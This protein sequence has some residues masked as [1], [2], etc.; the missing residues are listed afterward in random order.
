[1]P[2]PI[3]NIGRNTIVGQERQ[4]ISAKEAGPGRGKQSDRND[5]FGGKG[6]AGE[7]IQAQIPECEKGQARDQAAA[8]VGV[9]PRYVSDAA[10]LKK[11][12]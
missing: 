1:M 9:S 10:T 7:D 12:H 5:S 3:E 8:L 6:R 4:V 2:P 11:D